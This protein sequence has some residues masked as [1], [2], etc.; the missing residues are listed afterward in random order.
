MW[1]VVV[2]AMLVLL[3]RPV[4]S[5]QFEQL[6][7]TEWRNTLTVYLWLPALDGD[8]TVRDRTAHVNSSISDAWDAIANLE[9]G[10][11]LHYEGSKGP[12]TLIADILYMK[13]KAGATLGPGDGANITVR[14]SET[15]AELAEA[16]T[17][18]KWMRGGSVAGDTQILGGLRYTNLGMSLSADLPELTFS[19]SGRRW[20]IDPFL[21]ARYRQVLSPRWAYS[22]RGDIGG[23]GIGTASHFVWNVILDARYGLSHQ[24]GID[25][26]W[27][28][29]DYNYSTGSGSDEFAYDLL[30]NGPFLGFSYGF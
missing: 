25:M 27:R 20:W 19:A 22:V 13:L 7:P 1:L 16:Y 21:G 12:A 3:C 30:M 4:A 6:D 23:F 15:I 10:L 11:T 17:V 5:Q 26:G 8:V 2:S 14:P 18:S 29:L 28:W 9:S 24:W